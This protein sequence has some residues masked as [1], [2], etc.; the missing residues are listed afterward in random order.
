MSGPSPSPSRSSATQGFVS[1]DLNV[2]IRGKVANQS[3]DAKGVEGIVF[4]LQSEAGIEIKHPALTS[5]LSK[6]ESQTLFNI[7]TNEPLLTLSTPLIPSP[8]TSDSDSETAVDDDEED[9]DNP[10][11][12]NL[13]RSSSIS[14]SQSRSRSRPRP[15]K[16]TFVTLHAALLPASSIPELESSPFYSPT[17]SILIS[18]HNFPLPHFDPST[19][20]PPT[21]SVKPYTLD[22]STSS[23]SHA[24]GGTLNSPTLQRALLSPLL[25]PQQHLRRDASHNHSDAA[26]PP[27]SLGLSRTSRQSFST[28]DRPTPPR[29]PPKGLAALLPSPPIPQSSS[30]ETLTSTL[31]AG[32]SNEAKKTA[33]KII[34]LRREHEGFVKRA[35]AELEVLERRIE[36]FRDGSGSFEGV[37]PGGGGGVGGEGRE[38]VVRGFRARDSAAASASA[39]G[40]T[41]ASASRGRESYA[42]SSSP[43][44]SRSRSIG[45]SARGR[46]AE[47]RRSSLAGSAAA[48]E[49]SP[50][51]L[52]ATDMDESLSLRIRKADEAEEESRGRSRSRLRRGNGAGT[53]G[54]TGEEERRSRSRSK[55]VADATRRAV[56]GAMVKEK[57]KEK[58]QE[59]SRSRTR[60]VG[61]GDNERGKGRESE[62]TSTTMRRV[63]GEDLPATV[64]DSTTTSAATSPTSTAVPAPNSPDKLKE[65]K[66]S[67]RVDDKG[68][69]TTLLPPLPA[70]RSNGGTTPSFGPSSTS[71]ALLAVP[72]EEEESLLDSRGTSQEREK[73]RKK[74]SSHSVP[75]RAAEE[76]SDDTPFEMDEDVES[77]DLSSSSSHPPHHIQTSFSP[78]ADNNFDPTTASPLTSPILQSQPTTSSSFRPGSFQRASALSAS[79]AA[80]LS[81]SVS[82]ASP[83]PAP[84]RAPYSLPSAQSQTQVPSPSPGLGSPNTASRAADGLPPFSPPDVK[85]PVT[86]SARVDAQNALAASI[87]ERTSGAGSPAEEADKVNET[88]KG[89][90][91][92]RRDHDLLVR[93]G[94]QKIRDVLAMDVPSHRPLA[95]TRSGSGGGGGGGGRHGV[96]GSYRPDADSEDD[97]EGEDTEGEDGSEGGDTIEEMQTSIASLRSVSGGASARGGSAGGGGGQSSFQVGSLPISLGRPSTVNAALSSWRPDPERE[98]AM[99]RDNSNRAR[100]ASGKFA[101]TKSTTTLSS[102]SSAFNAATITSPTTFTASS[103]SQAL[104]L[105][106]PTATTSGSGSTFRRPPPTATVPA[107]SSSLSQSLRTHPGAASFS[108][109][110]SAESQSQRQRS[111]EQNVEE[112]LKREGETGADGQQGEEEENEEEEGFVPPH[113]IAARKAARRGEVPDGML[114]GRISG[115]MLDVGL[116]DADSPPAADVL[117]VLLRAPT[118]HIYAI[119]DP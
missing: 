28:S 74:G 24:L 58:E 113:L 101:P 17:F 68:A 14:P 27:L 119:F 30:T 89:H 81:S 67:E 4:E 98:W 50:Q 36:A 38:G 66:S 54:G 73:G 85:S 42:S 29:V 83:P 55:A 1:S 56:E 70:G 34:E 108:A 110:A 39:D 109:R 23:N 44:G 82:R 19:I 116:F 41:T 103:S 72:E 47:R 2:V 86:T 96:G 21:P 95:P 100:G 61:G 7:N 52:K 18:G 33:E 79:Y 118:Q 92:G 94:E 12:L 84:A 16:P 49:S 97:D 93:R 60:I 65:K 9:D 75:A 46:A 3:Q 63:E 32:L 37:G 11:P 104:D 57:E 117:S 102:S 64:A 90:G 25:S 43:G 87:L 78:A 51:A 62:G 80:L 115:V 111:Q 45:E 69:N 106:T 88:D 77:F 59:K 15:P 71:K 6:P 107:F 10:T 20:A 26:V 31:T 40:P 112:M 99:Q 13:A 91:N 53:G 76:R 114:G 48:G 105:G 35:K 22:S 5:I 8:S